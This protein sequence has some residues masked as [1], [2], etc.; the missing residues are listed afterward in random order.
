VDVYEV[1]AT[2]PA[3]EAEGIES[4]LGYAWDC[5]FRIAGVGSPR[6]RAVELELWREFR[7]ANKAGDTEP[8]TDEFEARLFARA[9]VLGWSNV[10]WKGRA[11]EYTEANA[12]MLLREVPRLRERVRMVA[13][14][15]APYRVDQDEGALKNSEV[16][17]PGEPG[18]DSTNNGSKHSR[19]AVS[20]H[21]RSQANLAHT[22]I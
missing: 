8:D 22:G 13:H 17:S 3:R 20:R 7:L 19:P 21:R 5:R 11:L 9:V 14:S 18:G 6:Y 16:S 15:A 12:A 4:D 10:E 2:D 1:L